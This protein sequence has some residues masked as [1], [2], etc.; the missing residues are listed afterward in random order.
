MEYL[1][2]PQVSDGA[3]VLQ[4]NV[5]FAPFELCQCVASSFCGSFCLNY[6]RTWSTPGGRP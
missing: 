2:L 6:C 5:D 4:S 1:V 3:E